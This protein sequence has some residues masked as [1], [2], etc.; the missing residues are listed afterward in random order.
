MGAIVMDDALIETEVILGAGSLVP[1]GQVL[2]AG[3]LWL[4]S[5]AK[6]IRPLTEREKQHLR[7]SANYY[8]M[9]GARHANQQK[10]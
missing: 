1:K 6:K 4:G 5:P 2:T 8:V 9:L 7:Y 3:H 10:D